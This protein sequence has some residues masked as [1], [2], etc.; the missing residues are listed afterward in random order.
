M[1]IVNGVRYDNVWRYENEDN[2]DGDLTVGKDRKETDLW[3]RSGE[4]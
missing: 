1:N 2:K 4:F 3:R